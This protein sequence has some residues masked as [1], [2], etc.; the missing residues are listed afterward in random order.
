MWQ[1]GARGPVAQEYGYTS[2]ESDMKKKL[3]LVV[4]LAVT[5]SVAKHANATNGMRLPGFGPVQNSMGGI[6]VGATLDGASI[7]SNPAGLADL[8]R[9]ID[10]SLTWFK[11]TVSYQATE[12]PLPAGFGGAVVARPNATIDSNRGASPIPLV[13]GVIP[14]SERLRVGIGATGIA[15][16]G[17]DYPVNLYGGRTYTSYLQG[18]I[19]PAVAYRINDVLAAGVTLNGMV[20]QMKYDVASGFGQQ[21][22]DT[23]TALGIGVT[24]GVKIN[25]IKQLTLGAAY[26]T[27]SFFQDFSFNIPAHAGVDPATFQPVQFPAGTD[28]LTFNQPQVVTLGASVTPIPVLLFAA[29]LEWINW[30]STNGPNK[31]AYSSNAAT[32][33]AQPFDL[34]WKNQWVVKLGAQV[35][36]TPR[37]RV[38]A[39]WNYG[40]NPLDASRAFEN[41]AFPAIAEH[42]IQFGA[43]YD[44]LEKL[45]VNLAGT[46]AP[47]VTQSGANAAYPAQGGQ[48][49]ASYT[50]Q[51]SQYQIDG[52]IAWRF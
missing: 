22:H 36:A 48:A 9:R 25:P 26:E 20:A 51:M 39:G 45:T 2:A 44:V 16:L 5:V 15:G 17:V 42:H 37:F 32:T 34:N 46:I 3:L 41:I 23:S 24:I 29:D 33:G 7:V 30:S 52:G 1:T 40:K 14:L 50:T 38:R 12:S 47:K 13:V 19:T 18:R 27:K 6:G 28:K 11:P 4:S 21:P 31:P 35:A 43:G 49:I 8:E 10:A